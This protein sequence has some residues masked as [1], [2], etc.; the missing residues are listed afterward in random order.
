[1]SK[2][3]LTYKLKAEVNREQFE[4]WQREFDYP[5]MRGLKR[6]SSFVN[7]RVIRPL[8]GEKAPSVD[9][10]E[11][12]EI[13]DLEGFIQEDM[14]GDVVQSVMGQFMGYVENP[15]FLIVEEVV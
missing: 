3:I 6:V 10:I 4:T 2:I 12:F 9:Y 1:M 5:S 13:S 8:I 15:E 7:H 11:V 14:G